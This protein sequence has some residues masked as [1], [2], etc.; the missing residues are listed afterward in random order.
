MNDLPFELFVAVRYL[1]AKRKQAFISLISMISV[2]GVG[3]GVM[4]VLIAMALMTGLQKEL[5]ERIV[6]S[7]AHVYVFKLGGGIEDI[8]SEVQKLKQV[9][10][11][12]GAAP[13][14]IG[15]GLLTSGV[16]RQSPVTMKGIEPSLEP[17]VTEIKSAMREGSLEALRVNPDEMD[18][19]VLGIDLAKNL[20]VKLGDTVRLITPDQVL[21]PFSP[22][23]RTRAFKVV[24]IF[25]LGL[26]EFDSE[27]AL[28][29]LPVG[30]RVFG[31]ERPDFMQVKLDDMFVSQAV[32]ED[33]PRKLGEDYATQD[34]AQ[35]NKSLFS[36]LWLEKMAIS[37]TIGLIIMVAALNIVASLVLLVMEKSRD[38]AILKTMGSSAASIRRIFMLQGLIIGLIGTGGGTILGMSLIYVL[39][40]YK[41]IRVPIDV[42]QISHIPFTL[43]P[44]DLLAVV[45]A[46]LLICFVAT[47]Y[48]SRQASKLDPA[49][50]LRYQ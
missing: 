24:G 35:M 34:W 12:V 29:D 31:K 5:R 49:Q 11:V 45:A 36:A 10:R 42:Y 6:G 1:L 20:D 28:V 14:V 47:I 16:D 13:A 8:P 50:A 39:D 15:K 48:P 9:P 22:M 26:F 2:L 32:A 46:A 44:R 30:E 33:I 19:I 21:T 25:S 38:I 3:V 37:I 40:H 43:L 23:P 41:L 4:A 17:T 18:G 7:S 27:Y